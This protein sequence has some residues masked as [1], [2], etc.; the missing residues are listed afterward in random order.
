M[1]EPPPTIET[2]LD[3][4]NQQINQDLNGYIFPAN[5]GYLTEE[6][7]QKKAAMTDDESRLLVLL[8]RIQRFYLI[9]INNKSLDG[10]EQTSLLIAQ[11]LG[12]FKDYQP[13]LKNYLVQDP[14]GF[15]ALSVALMASRNKELWLDMM[16]EIS[17]RLPEEDP[18]LI[19]LG[20][21]YR[22][23][24]KPKNARTGPLIERLAKAVAPV[25]RKSPLLNFFVVI[26]IGTW[27]LNNPDTNPSEVL[28]A[29]FKCI[30]GLEAEPPPLATL[31]L[32]LTRLIPV[33]V[34][35]N[36][37][38]RLYQPSYDLAKLFLSRFRLAHGQAR[39][40]I[41][42]FHG[43]AFQHQLKALVH[44]YF[45]PKPDWERTHLLGYGA[46]IRM[47]NPTPAGLFVE[48]ANEII[49]ASSALFRLGEFG[50]AY[51]LY[52]E[53]YDSRQVIFPNQVN[54]KTK[55]A[56]YCLVHKLDS[57][58]KNPQQAI[59]Q[60]NPHEILLITA[61]PPRDKK[62]KPDALS[63]EQIYLLLTRVYNR[64][65]AEAG[66]NDLTNL[67]ASCYTK[68][69]WV[70]SPKECQEL[71]ELL[72][73]PKSLPPPPRITTI[74]PAPAT[75]PTAPPQAPAVESGHET[76]KRP[77]AMRPAQQRKT[78][79]ATQQGAAELAVT[80][81]GLPGCLIELLDEL[82]TKFP[83]AK[84][85]LCG[86]VAVDL[87]F[88]K[89]FNDVDIKIINLA[90]ADLALFLT[91]KGLANQ[92]R[93]R[94]HPIL[95]SQ[96]EG[97]SVDFSCEPNSDNRPI[98]GLLSDDLQ[99]RDFNFAGL[100]LEWSIKKS[101]KV[102]SQEG[103]LKKLREHKISALRE[104]ADLFA[105]NVVCLF[106]LIKF[107]LKYPKFQLDGALKEYFDKKPDWKQIIHDQIRIP[108]RF[109]QIMAALS[110]LFLRFPAA[111]VHGQMQKLNLLDALIGLKVSE[112]NEAYGW[113]PDNLPKEHLA[114]AWL[115]VIV[116]KRGNRADHCPLISA[117]GMH[118][119]L[120][121]KYV[122]EI[123][124]GWPP[125]L[126]VATYELQQIIANY[127]QSMAE[128][129]LP[130]LQ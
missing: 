66:Q 92:Q 13:D 54:A 40:E 95:V 98:E 56:L 100:R 82:A 3:S 128:S 73:P 105:S 33:C 12:Q 7:L 91:N 86:G 125:S 64:A 77:Q 121:V 96:I 111:V 25:N 58:L 97:V 115:L 62:I 5:K 84:I 42:F 106:R 88:S 60:L 72:T 108:G 35:T 26:A 28:V 50:E 38:D 79:Q 65:R 103:I 16:K 55:F 130:Q 1:Y 123:A 94:I 44:V 122:R 74:A 83:Q 39:H 117:L 45:S 8:W 126:L 107:Q 116:L 129:V 110:Q 81:Q 15:L 2:L 113:I 80:K 85:Y 78:V 71:R 17:N 109:H 52:A 114:F 63:I 4:L 18:N 24:F 118:K 19:L 23:Y 89:P 75:L 90:L 127:R 69:A 51:Y 47:L 99:K 27:F 93:S 112:L 9:D 43:E 14:R 10:R 29:F 101:L 119:R 87:F 30:K 61:L 59:P 36:H 104:P 124:M 37:F 48:I 120:E 6:L 53:M 49:L 11:S 46:V 34:Q 57:W 102:L 32:L 20:W 76:V 31:F 22:F 21:T 70:L 67:C 41:A 68:L